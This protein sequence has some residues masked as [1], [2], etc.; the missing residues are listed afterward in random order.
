MTIVDHTHTGRSALAAVPTDLLIDG[1]W[2]AASD[3]ARMDVINP[4]TE[5][6]ITQVADASLVDVQAA[7]AAAVKAQAS[8]AAT[9]PRARS[10]ILYR[11][12]EEM[13]RRQDDLALIMTSEMGKP[14]AEAKGEVAYAAEFFRW[15]AEEAVR[16]DGGFSQR[17]DGTARTMVLRQPVGPCLL[18][19]PWNFPAAMGS[20]KMGPAIAAGCTMV[21]KPA[22]Q[23]PLTSLA[24]AQILQDVGL[25]KG[26]LNVVTTSR[27]AEVIEP[28]LTG[29]DIRKLSFTGSTAVGKILLAQAAQQVVRCSMELGGN[30]PFIVLADADMDVA[31]EAAMQ[32]KM[33]NMGEACTAANRMFVHSSVVDEFASRLAERMGALKVGN[34]MDD[35]VQVGPMI[36]AASRDKVL[37]L[38]EDAIQRGARVAGGGNASGGTGFFVEP[39]VLT[40][41]QPGSDLLSAEIFGPVAAIQTFETVDEVLAIAND[42]EWGLVGYVITQ[43]VDLAFEMSERLEVG[44][45]GLNTGLV[46]TPSAPFGGI[47]HSGLGREGGRLGIEEFLDVK[48]I[49]MPIRERGR[50]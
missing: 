32:A 45:V 24:L 34:G 20:R 10:E 9:A 8:W 3:S 35:G 43:D 2:R 38:A 21:L 19:T 25:P 7:V 17:P 5:Q 12:Y 6:V 44:M 47:K 39:T 33:R 42:T 30:A 16:I 1:T 37:R 49:A 14:F 13:M 29:G 36:D 40:D 50:A 18:L 48:Y 11:A 41:V 23:T 31:V 27:A 46:S 28:V 26:V 4:A 15:F 22:P